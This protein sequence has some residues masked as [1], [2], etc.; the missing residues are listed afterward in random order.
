MT[1]GGLLDPGF[2]NGGLLA[3]IGN[4]LGGGQIDGSEILNFFGGFTADNELLRYGLRERQSAQSDCRACEDTRFHFA[5]LSS[6]TAIVF[7]DST[8]CSAVRQESA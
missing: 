5:P 6:Y 2:G 7:Q 1:N 8:R 4:A 3:C